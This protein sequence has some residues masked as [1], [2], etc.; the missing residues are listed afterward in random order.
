MNLHL[1]L[2]NKSKSPVSEILV[3]RVVQKTLKDLS[4]DFLEKKEITISVAVVDEREIKDLNKKF[5]KINKTTD[6]LSFAE[7]GNIQSIE[8]EKSKEMFLGELILCYN[9]IADYAKGKKMK[10]KTELAEVISHGVLHLLGFKHG[11]EMFSIQKK[12]AANF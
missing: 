8:K 1:E 5:R 6:I 11:N 4:F 7:Y 2:N 3:E 12:I 10:I 9:D